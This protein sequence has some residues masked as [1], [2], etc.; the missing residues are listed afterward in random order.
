MHLAASPDPSG[1]AAC[2]QRSALS[3]VSRRTKRSPRISAARSA[4]VLGST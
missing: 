1:G 4:L 3:S 2:C